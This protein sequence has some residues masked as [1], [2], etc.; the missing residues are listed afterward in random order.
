MIFSCAEIDFNWYTED[1]KKRGY[2]Q[3][4]SMKFGNIL[5]INC[6]TKAAYF[7]LITRPADLFSGFSPDGLGICF[8]I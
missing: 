3:H 6:I 1:T 8:T 4:K 5:C 2:I 7:T